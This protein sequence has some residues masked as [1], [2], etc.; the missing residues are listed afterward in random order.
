L[1]PH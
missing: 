1:N